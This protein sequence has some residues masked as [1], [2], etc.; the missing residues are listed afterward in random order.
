MAE[1]K[2]QNNFYENVARYYDKDADLG[3]EQWAG[4]N[5][6]LEKIRDDFRKITI[7]YPFEKALEIGCGPGFDVSWFA[8][9]FPDREVTGVDISPKMVGLT[10]KRIRKMNLDNAQ[11]L[12]SDER[13]LT[14]HFKSEEFDLIY[15][16]FGA[17]NTVE[18]LGFA[19]DQIHN[20]LKPHGHAVLTF[21]NKWYLREMVVQSL[22]LNF[23]TAFAR[24]KKEWGGYSVDRHLPSKCYSP[25]EIR[26]SFVD[27]ELMEKKG[28]SIL[29]PAWYNFKK[30]LNQ[31]EKINK[32]W[33]KDQQLQNTHWW[34]KGEYTLFV[35]RK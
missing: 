23:K 16:Y 15:V 3:F 32:H 8:H 18:D 1:K 33:K 20:L 26:K 17:L 7:K 29:F 31:Q 25:V 14:K 5:P 13:D 4:E 34:S 9:E 30:F 24:L 2:N 21:V 6:L 22:K 11:V 27:F 12:V 35:F 10:Q 19:A 28:Y